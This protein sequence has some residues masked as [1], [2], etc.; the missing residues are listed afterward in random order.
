MLI[1]GSIVVIVSF[2]MDYVSFLHE[3]YSYKEIFT[4]QWTSN[5]IELADLYVPVYFNWWVF[6][7]GMLI[8]IGGIVRF[9]WRS[10]RGE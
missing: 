2:T 9:V 8:I 6:S 5:S 10:R 4:W 7:A 1:L 3:F